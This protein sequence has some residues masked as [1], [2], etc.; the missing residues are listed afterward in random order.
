[1]YVFPFW[2][3]VDVY[4]VAD[5]RRGTES[6]GLERGGKGNDGIRK[7]DGYRVGVLC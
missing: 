1:M 4:K 3:T 5:G 2:S 7:L 6:M